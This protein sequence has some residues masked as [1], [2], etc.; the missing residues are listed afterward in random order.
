MIFLGEPNQLV[1][2]VKRKGLDRIRKPLFRFDSNGEYETNDP[3][4]I[5]KCRKHF[6]IKEEPRRKCKKCDFTCETQGELLKH[7]RE[8]HPKE[9]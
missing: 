8:N 3:K 7:Y 2:N 6:Q 9:D 5:E 4:I 1:M